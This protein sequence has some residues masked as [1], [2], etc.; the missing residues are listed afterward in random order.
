MG[1]NLDKLKRWAAALKQNIFALY[2][3]SRDPL[4]PIL[5]K[6]VIVLTI[7]YALSPIDL[8][9]D[10]I[11]VI[12][13]LDDLLLL[14]G[15]IWLAIRLIPARV[16]Q[17]CK[18]RAETESFTLPKSRGAAVVVALLWLLL[19]AWVFYWWLAT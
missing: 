18:A 11:P 15:G 1:L 7:G 3:A 12:G 6:S 10:F 16:W 8:I 13:Y 4:T 19:C 14:P 9:P 5:A 2:L 17:E